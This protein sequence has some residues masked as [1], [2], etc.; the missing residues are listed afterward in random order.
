MLLYNIYFEVSAFAFL[1]VLNMYIRLQYPSESP[2]NRLFKRLALVLL[3]AVTLDVTTAITISYA[4]YVPIWLN[5]VLNTMY[6]IADV[7]LEYQFVLYCTYVTFGDVNK[8]I[9]P[10]ISLAASILCLVVLALNIFTGWVF[11]FDE[12]GYVHGPIY[13]MVYIVPIA[14]LFITCGMMLYNFPRFT[15]RQRISIILYIAALT[16][17]PIVQ[18]LLPHILFFLFTISIGLLL[19]M[20]ALETPDFQTLNRTMEELRTTRDEAEEAM[21]AAQTANQAKNDFLSGMSHEIRT[22]INAILGYNEMVLRETNNAEIAKYSTNVQ[23]AGKT[24]LNMIS[25]MMDYTEMETGSF[26][27]EST[28][29]SSASML[30]D[31]ASYSRYSAKKKEITLRLDFDPEIPRTLRGDSVRITRIFNNLISN[32]V[33]YTDAGSIEVSVRWEP[34]DN[35]KG[36]LKAFVSDTGI[37]MREE[38]ISR[39]SLSF[40][41]LEKKRNQN[42]QGIGLGLTIVT[43]LLAMMGSSLEI[44]SEYGR[45]TKMSFR[46]EQD[47]TDPEPL[48]DTVPT[49]APP[50]KP[51]KP[52]YSAPGVRILAADDNTMN[53]ELYRASLKEIQAQTDTAENGMEALE[54]ISKNSYDLILLD[55]MMPVMDGMDTLKTIKKQNLCPNVPIIVITANAVSGEKNVYLNAGF[56]DYLSKPVSSKQ[57]WSTVKKYLPAGMIRPEDSE[58]AA[59]VHPNRTVDRLS[60]FLDTAKALQ[61]CCE[62]E[63]LYLEIVGTYLE[64]DKTEMI[65]RYCRENDLENYRIQ[66]HALK[67]SSRTIGANALSEKA[68]ALETAARG[69]DADYIAQNTEPVLK[70]YSEI[71]ERIRKVVNSSEG[72]DLDCGSCDILC[73]DGDAMYRL[74]EERILRDRFGKVSTVP[75]SAEALVYLRENSAGAVLLD[76]DLDGTDGY[77]LLNQL[78]ADEALSNIPVVIF[79]SDNSSESEVRYLRAGASDYLTKPASGDVLTERLRKAISCSPASS[80]AESAE[81]GETA[82]ILS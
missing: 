64:E 34:S 37:G 8:S 36:F 4:L 28:S 5:V 35:G 30:S 23:N 13:L 9:I 18:M 39:I 7:V 41:R 48:G 46:L 12:T 82:Q 45:G 75:S 16:S 66:V 10:K 61:Y 63:E 60:E 40:L 78:K 24:L 3:L 52:D 80:S 50:E 59:A 74:L 43:R 76:P 42:I 54:L 69:G 29:Y 73:V 81:I 57:L 11:S 1:I 62:S 31:I 14:L 38:D 19:L 67:S 53:L 55:H 21:A 70:E 49:E 56:D 58:P 15:T 51:G 65:T 77:S 68:F 2:S 47:V 32:A 25:D 22:P 26:R 33:K 27:I 44:D 72:G 20:F 71:M 79:T 17:G 6:F